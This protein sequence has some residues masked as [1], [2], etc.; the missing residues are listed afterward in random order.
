MAEAT[1]SRFVSL[2]DT[3]E[4]F[5][6]EHENPN[7]VKKTK[8]EVA[9]LTVFLQTKGETR[10]IAEIPPVELNELLSEFILS[11]RTKE[12]QE[13]EPSSLRGMVASFERH[14][15]RKSYP[16][17]IIN[18]LAFE[19]LRKTLQSK[20]KQLKKQGRGN[21]PNASVALTEDEIKLLFDKGL[22]G[23]SSPEAILNTLW[24]N[25]SLHFGLRGVKEHHD[26]RWGDVKLCKTDQG[27]EYLEFNER[28]TK[29][30][31]GADHRDVRPFAPKMFST[32]GSEKDPVAVYKL[33]VQKRPEK[34]KDPDAP[35]YIAVN[36]VSM[37]SK[38]SNSEK[39]WFKCN[40]VGT[41]KLGGLMKEMSKKAGLQND[42]LRNHSARKTMIQTLSENNVPPTQIA[43]LSGHKNLKSIENYSHLSTKQ[44]MHMSNVLANI[45]SECSSITPFT[46]TVTPSTSAVFRPEGACRFSNPGQQSMALFSGAVIHGGQFSVTIN[47]VNQSP[48]LPPPSEK[49]QWKRIR[50]SSD[51]DDD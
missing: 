19:K 4:S 23:V 24:L 40:A 49:R 38:P 3:I 11:V 16:V 31:T 47:T 7:T 44:E 51:S 13:Y 25:N 10:E 35:F 17:S 34:M 32:D 21:K 45:S 15:K 5:I 30:R 39:C 12:G 37:K 20:Q 33:F 29:T 6:E 27:V 43:Q 8:R 50:V 36:N 26:M 42:K 46:P 28:Q 14:L 48:P 22:L 41:N 9:L 2:D 1:A 18:D